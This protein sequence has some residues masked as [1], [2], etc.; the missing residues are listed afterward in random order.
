MDEAAVTAQRMLLGEKMADEF[1][2]LAHKLQSSMLEQIPELA[3]DSVVVEMLGTSIRSNL[4]TIA[5]VLRNVVDV[6][7][8][9]APIGAREYAERLAQ[10]GVS[11]IALLRA[12]RLGQRILMDWSFSKLDETVDPDVALASYH[13]FSGLI[14]RYVD[15]IS[16]QVVAEYQ[17]EHERW[18]AHRSNVVA[19]ILDQLLAGHPVDVDKAEVVLDH[20]LRQ[21]HLGVL[22]WTDA[23]TPEVLDPARLERAVARL[24]RSMN[25]SGA[26]L[27]WPKDRVTGW[28]WLVVDSDEELPDLA[29]FDTALM[30]T[31]PHVRV[32]LGTPAVGL[33][34]FRATHLEARRAQQVALVAGGRAPRIVSY[35]DSGVRFTSLLVDDLEAARRFVGGALGGLAEDTVSAERLR[36]TALVFLEMKGSHTTTAQRLHLHKN[37]VKYRLKRAAE[38]RGRPVDEERLDLELALI[39]C[40]WLGPAVLSDPAD[41]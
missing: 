20:G 13:A 25:G 17:R 41:S 39:A 32:A 28:A 34:G 38:K 29:Q 15:S 2:K 8:V 16:E 27:F 3:V 14:Y 31:E 23:P 24:N 40:R 1:P 11:L 36:Q 6:E 7:S 4:E 33:E 9:V 22:V 26:V 19:E 10:R 30:E 5:Q 21:T 37:S 18:I 12:Y 35:G